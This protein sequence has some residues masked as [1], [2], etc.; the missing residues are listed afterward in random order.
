ME[1]PLQ[2][3][4]DNSREAQIGRML[5]ALMLEERTPEN[6]KRRKELLDELYELE[7]QK[8]EQIQKRSSKNDQKLNGTP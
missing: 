3:V 5:W 7:Q 2:K 4:K 8:K 6:M 1:N